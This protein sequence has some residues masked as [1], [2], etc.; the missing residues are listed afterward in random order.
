MSETPRLTINPDA[1]AIEALGRVVDTTIN[2]FFGNLTNFVTE[3]IRLSGAAEVELA[4]VI[5][6]ENY[7]E[8]FKDREKTWTT[9]MSAAGRGIDRIADRVLEFS[10]ES[11]KQ[12]VKEDERHHRKMEEE[13]ARHNLMTE[14]HSEAHNELERAKIQES[15]ARTDLIKAVTEK[16]ADAAVRSAR[17]GDYGTDVTF[18]HED[19]D[20]DNHVD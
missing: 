8:V 2:S 6:P 12:R 7:V 14:K 10:K 3:S 18:Y 15:I 11:G 13:V 5:G 20:L 1:K 19:S 17:V 4:E 16:M 9:M